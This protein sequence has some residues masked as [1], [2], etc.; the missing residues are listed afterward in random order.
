MK[1]LVELISQVKE[2]T[3]LISKMGRGNKEYKKELNNFMSDICFSL[4]VLGSE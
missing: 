3:M 2:I 4:K 1:K